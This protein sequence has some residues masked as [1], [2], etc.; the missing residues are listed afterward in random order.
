[1]GFKEDGPLMVKCLTYADAKM[2]EKPRDRRGSWVLVLT[3]PVS[4]PVNL[5]QLLAF[6]RTSV[7]GGVQ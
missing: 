2:W 5:L 1:M 4:G 7:S 3:C 6:L